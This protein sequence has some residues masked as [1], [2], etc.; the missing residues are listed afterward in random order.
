MVPILGVTQAINTLVYV[1]LGVVPFYADAVGN[2]AAATAASY[3]A[4][5]SWEPLGTMLLGAAGFSV[6]FGRL[7]GLALMAVLVFMIPVAWRRLT[8][9]ERVMWPAALL[10]GV[11]VY[12][13]TWPQFWA[14]QQ[15]VLA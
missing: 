5:F 2:G 11:L 15:W 9:M 3:S 4:P 7:L 6:S 14:I 12:A 1:L 10:V 13:L 8:P